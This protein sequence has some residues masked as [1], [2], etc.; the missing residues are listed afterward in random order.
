MA[1]IFITGNSR[2]L[3][4]GLTRFY[5]AQGDEVY[6]LSRSACPIDHANLHSRQQDLSRLSELDEALGAL[7]PDKIDLAILNAGILGRIRDLADTPMED[8]RQIMDINL[9]AN[10]VIIDGLIKRPLALRQLILMSSGASVNGN[11]GWGAY[12]ISKAALNMLAKLYAHEM[13]D[14]HI[15]AY[16][17]GLVH[18]QMQDYLCHDVDTIKF[19]SMANLVAAYHTDAMP[20]IDSAAQ[21]IARSFTACLE[22]PSGSFLDIRQL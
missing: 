5:L 18:T 3:G 1:K 7:L 4:L 6:S 9:W 15:T 19:P 8:I 13:P 12:S 14:T 10:K 11:R 21:R 17:P 16:A 22:Y 2:G 20:D